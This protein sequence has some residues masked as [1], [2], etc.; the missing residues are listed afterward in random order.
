MYI[1]KHFYLYLTSFTDKI[2]VNSEQPMCN[3]CPTDVSFFPQRFRHRSLLGMDNSLKKKLEN[4]LNS[5]FIR[6]VEVTEPSRGS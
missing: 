1:I 4:K 6:T 2:K 3:Q 5:T